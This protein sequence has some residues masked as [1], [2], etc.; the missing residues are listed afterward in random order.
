MQAQPEIAFNTDAPGPFGELPIEAAE[1]AVMALD[2]PF[3]IQAA[4][5][6]LNIMAE[7]GFDTAEELLLFHG[8]AIKEIE[9]SGGALTGSELG[10]PIIINRYLAGSMRRFTLYHELGHHVL[11]EHPD[12][13]DRIYYYPNRTEI[14]CEA[15]ACLMLS[16]SNK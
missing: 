2:D 8:S 16:L 14:L 7:N 5:E 6:Q 9:M 11:P 13:A 3:V 1:D 15:F 12:L 10:A 4:V